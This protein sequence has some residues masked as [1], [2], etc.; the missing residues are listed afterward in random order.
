MEA[1]PALR[2]DLRWTLY[3]EDPVKHGRGRKGQSPKPAFLGLM[4]RDFGLTG[5]QRIPGLLPE[6][7]PTVPE[8]V[9]SRLRQPVPATTRELLGTL[10]RHA[11]LSPHFSL[12]EPACCL[13]VV[14]LWA[15]VILEGHPSVPF[16]P[17]GSRYGAVIPVTLAVL[18]W[19]LHLLHAGAEGLVVP[20]RTGV[21]RPF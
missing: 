13:E 2:E 14:A 18:A 1:L 8:R 21:S 7:R 6:A 19:F 9:P 16:D 10:W 12:R 15:K 3:L 20:S 11:S 4:L 17:R 5:Y